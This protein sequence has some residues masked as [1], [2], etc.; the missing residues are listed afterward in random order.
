ML[1]MYHH[2][3][4]AKLTCQQLSR[5]MESAPLGCPCCTTGATA[6]LCEALTLMLQIRHTPL[7]VNAACR[8]LKCLVCFLLCIVA[9]PCTQECTPVC[10]Y[11][12]APQVYPA[13]QDDIEVAGLITYVID[14]L[15][16]R[17]APAAAAAAAP[18]CLSFS[19][20]AGSPAA[21]V[22]ATIYACRG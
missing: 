8:W 18:G 17:Q 1:V 7:V 13:T 4:H 2:A 9:R 5:R 11:W 10:A 19:A 15:W 22:P 20:H 12:V 6:G 3:L 16:H 14:H 21:G